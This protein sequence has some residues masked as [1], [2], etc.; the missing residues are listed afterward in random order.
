MKIW[1]QILLFISLLTFTWSSASAHDD[2]CRSKAPTSLLN[3]LAKHAPELSAPSAS[4]L[5]PE[6]VT[7]D[8]KAGGDGCYVVTSGAFEAAR[9]RDVALIL[10][11]KRGVPEL[12][13]AS[14]HGDSWSIERLPAFCDDVRSCYVKR[15]N[16]GVYARSE[17]LDAPI[18]A[19][20]E[21]ERLNAAHDVVVSGRL[22]STGV[23]HVYDSGRWLYVWTSD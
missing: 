7:F 21:R 23:T 15:G 16:P 5:E 2:I 12:I 22:E 3:H 14:H 13:V 8:K 10:G 11:S 6:S 18:V 17:A 20:D 4:D 9:R 1:H 19:S